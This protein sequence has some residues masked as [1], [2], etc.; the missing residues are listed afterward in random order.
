MA[1]QAVRRVVTGTGSD[2]RSGIDED[3]PCEAVLE[4]PMFLATDIWVAGCGPAHI[5]DGDRSGGKVVLEPPDRGFLVRRVVFHPDRQ[6]LGSQAYLAA[7]EAAGGGASHAGGAHDDG[8]H[9]TRTVDVAYVVEG[10]I[11]AVLEGAETTLRAG[12]SLIQR[13]TK[14]AW[15]NRTD[16]DAVVLFTQVSTAG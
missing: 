11:V 14:H 6:W 13:G 8:M 4:T 3:R 16:E 5:A 12:D 1:K 15:S 10:E 2:G 7:L 9:V